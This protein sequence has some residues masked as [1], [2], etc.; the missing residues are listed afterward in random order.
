MKLDDVV[1]LHDQVQSLGI[2]MWLDG[3]WAV[4]ALLGRQTRSH[5]DVDIVV[6]ETHL[7]TLRAILEKQGFREVP[8]DDMS[9]WN[10]VLGDVDGRFVDVH[11]IALDAEGNGIYGPPERGVMY[12]AESLTGTGVIGG[13]KVKCISAEYL[14]KWHTGYKLRDKDVEDVAALCTRFGIELPEEFLHFRS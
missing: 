7:P 8:R 4:D 10:S 11:V 3:G 13:R 12:P 5:E 6:Q 9:V 2:E 14:V 1:K